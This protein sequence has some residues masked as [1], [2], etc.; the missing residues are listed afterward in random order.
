MCAEIG[1]TQPGRRFKCLLTSTGT[2]NHSKWSHKDR[3]VGLAVP[4]RSTP[5]FHGP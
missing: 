3:R 5:L 2:Q 1:S 4:D